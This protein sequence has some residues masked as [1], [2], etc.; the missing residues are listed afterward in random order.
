MKIRFAVLG[1]AI[2]GAAALAACGANGGNAAPPVIACVVPSGTQVALAYPI[3]GSTGVPDSPGQIVVATSPALPNSWQVVLQAGNFQ[4]AESVFNAI[5]Q[6]SVP[7]PM[8]TPSFANPTYQ[9]SG[10]SSGLAPGTTFT[11]LL[12][13]QASN[14]NSFPALGSF[15]TQ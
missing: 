15:T 12:N 7:T 5:P 10:L 14:C 9:S 13:N 8:A 6:S 4:Q 1:G 2:A 11:V 3:S